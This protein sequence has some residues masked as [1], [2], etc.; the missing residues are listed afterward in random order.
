MLFDPVTT[1]TKIQLNSNLT[2]LGRPQQQPL[3]PSSRPTSPMPQGTSKQAQATNGT[4]LMG[5]SSTD[6]TVTDPMGRVPSTE[7]SSNVRTAPDHVTTSHEPV[8]AHNLT[9]TCHNL[10]R[11]CHNLTRTCHNLARTC[12]NLI[13]TCHNLIQTKPQGGDK[14]KKKSRFTVKSV[15]STAKVCTPF[16]H[17]LFAPELKTILTRINFNPALFLS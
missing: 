10:T 5:R 16:L 7:E 13:R 6:P 2:H 4:I 12:H 1:F 14:T 9:R 17:T 11:T 8:T 3:K 15:Q